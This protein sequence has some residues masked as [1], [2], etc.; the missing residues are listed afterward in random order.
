METLYFRTLQDTTCFKDGKLISIPKGTLYKSVP[1]NVA[2]TVL[3]ESLYNV[4][5]ETE[6]TGNDKVYEL[7][8]ESNYLYYISGD[9]LRDLKNFDAI[10]HG[11]NCFCSMG[12]GI[13]AGVAKIFP[14]ATAIDAQTTSGDKKKLGNITFVQYEDHEQHGCGIVINAYTQFHPGGQEQGYD[15][16]KS[17]EIRE[18]AIRKSMK[19]IKETFPGK[20]ISLPLIGAGIA[21]GNWDRIEKIIREELWG[22]D[23]TVVVWEKDESFFEYAIHDM[24]HT[25]RK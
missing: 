19:K 17:V 25:Y 8:D 22:E 20:K 7:V 23:V 18:W 14:E 13:A 1:L 6:I 4:L 9:L 12:A 5:N 21:G 15:E 11:C 16:E 3:F 10:V 24:M 2:G